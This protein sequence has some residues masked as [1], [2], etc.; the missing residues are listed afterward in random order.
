[1]K[2]DS[3]DNEG[4]LVKGNPISQKATGLNWYQEVSNI[5]KKNN[6]P[7]YLVWANFGDTNFYVPYRHDEN[8]GHEMANEFIDFYNDNSSVFVKGTEAQYVTIPFSSFVGKKGGSLD[9]KNITK[10]AV[11]CNSIIPEGHNGEW[12][13]SSTIYFEQIEAI[14]ISENDLKNVKYTIEKKHKY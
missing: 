13:V 1:M 3:S 6:M 14:T 2:A 7:Y 5:A 8:Y 11:W 4:L 9:T 10:F 12:K